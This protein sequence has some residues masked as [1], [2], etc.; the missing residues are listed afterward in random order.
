VRQVLGDMGGS[1]ELED[2]QEKRGATFAI[3]IIPGGAKN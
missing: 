3:T 1:I 2:T